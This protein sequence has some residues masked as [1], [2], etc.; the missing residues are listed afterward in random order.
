[1][2]NI[3]IINY[4]LHTLSTGF[5]HTFKKLVINLYK[6]SLKHKKMALIK[7]CPKT[8]RRHLSTRQNQFRYSINFLEMNESNPDLRTSLE[9][10]CEAQNTLQAASFIGI[11][12]GAIIRRDG[13]ITFHLPYVRREY[14]ACRR[15]MR[16]IYL[17]PTY[18]RRLSCYRHCL[19]NVFLFVHLIRYKM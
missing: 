1:M 16:Y 4:L 10:L 14:Q 12:C 9:L 17:T 15:G 13:R 18:I 6:V 19:R 11:M 7:K 2:E 5:V 8:E 3:F